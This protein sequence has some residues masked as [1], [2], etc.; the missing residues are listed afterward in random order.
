M[1]SLSSMLADGAYAEANGDPDSERSPHTQYGYEARPGSKSSAG[2]AGYASSDSPHSI[3]SL[4]GPPDPSLY[5]PLGPDVIAGHGANMRPA[6]AGC[7]DYVACE[8]A[9]RREDKE[10]PITLSKLLDK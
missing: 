3:T 1:A 2:T 5:S 6:Y 10:G 4:L 7:T 9:A 8:E